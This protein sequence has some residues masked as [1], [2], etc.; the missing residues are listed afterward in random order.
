MR[1]EDAEVIL[2][3]SE[4]ANRIEKFAA[5]ELAKY[6]T[7][8]VDK[9]VAITT[10]QKAQKAIYVGTLPPDLEKTF[11][12]KISKE[13]E[14][15]GDDGFIIR[16]SEDSLLILG[17]TPRATLF[18]V[19]HYLQMLGV[20]WYFPGE[21]NEYVPK[22]EEIVMKGLNVKESPAF[23]KRGIVIDFNNTALSDWIDFMAKVKLNTLAFH[24]QD[25]SLVP[26]KAM[27][28]I[29]GKPEAVKQTLDLLAKRGLDL[30][31]E[32]HFFGSKFCSV[33]QNELERSKKLLREFLERVPPEKNDFFLW[34]AD[35]TLVHCDCE[36][37][38]DLSLSDQVLLFMNQ[39]M[40]VI[41]ETRPD[42]RLTFIQYW[43]T[44]QPPRSVKPAD[45]IFLEIAPIHQCFSHSIRDPVCGINRNKV[46]PQIE[47]AL[48]LFNPKEAQVLGYWLD[49]SLFG[50]GEFKDLFGR[51][52]QF[53]GVIK[54]DFDYYWKKGIPAITTFAVGVDKDYFST[55]TSPTVFQYAQLLW[56]PQADLESEL[57]TFCENFYG[58]S[59][60]AQIFGLYEQIDPK[61][62]L[63]QECEHTWPGYISKI[64][65]FMELTRKTSVMSLQTA[66]SAESA[67]IQ[68]RLKRLLRELYYLRCW[69][70]SVEKH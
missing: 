4:E 23:A 65:D 37:D 15:L 28:Q 6:L 8:M 7:K 59:D 63:P 46:L 34:P 1:N 29:R 42:A 57:L 68:T 9:K 32:I 41:R 55:F 13:L 53:G 52:P 44:W 56:N 33:D 17:K 45:G 60:L 61:D 49:S 58:H 26:H 48:K 10:Q 66:D 31:L 27:D 22:R 43:S 39:M 2:V 38:R 51:L 40:Q 25:I 70:K 35:R 16:E 18:G 62:F 5:E 24:T 11:G 64:S 50:R 67:V 21:E 19:Y 54:Q 12:K 20:R 30:D 47:E 36:Q 69:L 14:E 3:V